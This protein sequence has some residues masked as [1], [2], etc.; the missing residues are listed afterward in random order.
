MT[1][2]EVVDDEVEV[3]DEVRNQILQKTNNNQLNHL[4][5]MLPHE[6]M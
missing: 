5:V 2:T 4:R 3:E 1:I 6:Q